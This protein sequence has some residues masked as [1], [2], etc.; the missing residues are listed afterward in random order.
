M[1]KTFA[2]LFLVLLLALSAI[3][4]LAEEPTPPMPPS[5]FTLW[6]AVTA[7]DAANHTFSVNVLISRGG[8]GAP[9]TTATLH[10][11]QRTRFAIHTDTGNVPGAFDDL[12]V[13]QV[14]MVSGVRAQGNFYAQMVLINAPLPPQLFAIGGKITALDGTAHALTLEVVRAMPPSLGILPGDSVVITTDENTHFCAVTTPG[15]PCT[16]I[17]FA[18][19]AVDDHV[20]TNGAVVNSAFLARQVTKLP[21]PPQ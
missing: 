17:T 2:F 9:P 3:P 20:M 10:T 13:D 5:R 8:R 16:P 1:K 4:A 15:Q 21:P 19:L 14:V 18:D 7:V 6:G 12:A 11:N